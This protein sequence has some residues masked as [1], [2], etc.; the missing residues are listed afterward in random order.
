MRHEKTS[1]RLLQLVALLVDEHQREEASRAGTATSDRVRPEPPTYADLTPYADLT[2]QAVAHQLGCTTKGDARWLA[3]YV[4]DERSGMHDRREGRARCEAGVKAWFLLRCH[5]SVVPGERWC[6]QHHPSPPAQTPA[7]PRLHPWD[8]ALRPDG[9]VLEAL[10]ELVDQQR[11]LARIVHAALSRLERADQ[12]REEQAPDL[13]TAQ[14]TA[15]LLGVTRTTVYDMCRS[16]RLP[17]LRIGRQYR[18]R[19]HDLDAWLAER[20]MPRLARPTRTTP[21]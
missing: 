21:T 20:T 3:S 8:L 5:R 1:P 14:Q 13:L 18:F 2:D 12:R 16:H 17:W 15:D 6:R 11:D 7:S 9:A 4:A 19:T 10:Y